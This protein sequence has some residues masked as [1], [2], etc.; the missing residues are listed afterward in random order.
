MSLLAIPGGGPVMEFVGRKVRLSMGHVDSEVHPR[1]DTWFSN[2]RRVQNKAVLQF[3]GPLA[4]RWSRLAS[5]RT[6]R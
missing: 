5:W 2:A 3:W 1:E 4:V 6:W